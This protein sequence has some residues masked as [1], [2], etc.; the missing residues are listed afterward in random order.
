QNAKFPKETVD[1]LKAWLHRHS[2]LPYLSEEEGKQLCHATGLSIS[3]VSSWMA[4]VSSSEILI[5]ELTR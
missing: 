5:F 2:D 1:L 4:N 3:Q